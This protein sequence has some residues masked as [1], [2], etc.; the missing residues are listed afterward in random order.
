MSNGLQ[1]LN[2]QNKLAEWAERVADRRN[3]GMS[4]SAWCKANGVCEQTYYKW[5][6]RLYNMAKAQQESQF[7]EITPISSIQ[8]KGE[9][10]VAVR[11]AG[12]TADIHTDADAATVEAVLRILKSC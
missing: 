5:Q 3:S 7:A 8:T 4:V 12:A 11:I 1:T 2:N 6:R 9:I 10:S